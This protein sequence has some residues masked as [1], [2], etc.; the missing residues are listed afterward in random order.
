MIFPISA[1]GVA[2]IIEVS[3]RAWPLSS[4]N[5]KADCDIRRCCG[6]SEVEQ[7]QTNWIFIVTV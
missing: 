2:R 3:H 7:R 6:L 4:F 5:E 1:S